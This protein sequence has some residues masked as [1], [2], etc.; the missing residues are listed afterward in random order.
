MSPSYC[1]ISYQY[2][3]TPELSNEDASAIIFNENQR[4]FTF[5]SSNLSLEGSY[6]ITIHAYSPV[7]TRSD[8]SLSF[9]VNFINPCKTATLTIDPNIFNADPIY[10][11]LGADA[12]T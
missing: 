5:S 4:T 12:N 9:L 1:P 3:V 10:Y 6:T 7:G 8:T 11:E 2:I